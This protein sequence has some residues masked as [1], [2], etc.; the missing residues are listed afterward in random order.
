MRVYQFSDFHPFFEAC[1]LAQ[2]EKILNDVHTPIHHEEID[3]LLEI[4]PKLVNLGYYAG[5]IAGL[6]TGAV[7]TIVPSV[8]TF[9]INVGG[10]PLFSWP[11]FAIIMFELMVLFSCTGAII[12]FLFSHRYPRYDRN[13]F[14][15]GEFQNKDKGEYF[16][17]TT[18]ELRGISAPHSYRLTE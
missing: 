6:F 13:I 10:R 3:E 11:A 2:E 12:G 8:F 1:R 5:G 9:P 17:V 14:S 15:L 16:L 4:K 7:I 18:D